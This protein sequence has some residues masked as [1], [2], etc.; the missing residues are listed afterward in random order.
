[1][2]VGPV[3]DAALN[4]LDVEHDCLLDGVRSPPT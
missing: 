2:K 3:R 1:V 4:R